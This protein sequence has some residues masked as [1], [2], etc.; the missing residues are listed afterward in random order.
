MRHTVALTSYQTCCLLG[1]V[2]SYAFACPFRTGG[3]GG[4]T[5]ELEDSKR[6]VGANCEEFKQIEDKW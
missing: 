3:G 4:H 1:E 2:W 5:M 6:E